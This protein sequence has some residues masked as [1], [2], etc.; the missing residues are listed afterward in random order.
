MRSVGSIFDPDLAMARWQHTDL[1]DSSPGRVEGN[2]LSSFI[3][4]KILA[5]YPLRREW[6]YRPGIPE[7]YNGDLKMPP[8]SPAKT[9]C[10]GHQR[11]NI[12]YNIPGAQSREDHASKATM[13]PFHLS[14][15]V[16]APNELTDA[17]EFLSRNPDGNIRA[18]WAEQLRRL[19]VLGADLF[20]TQAAWYLATPPEI[21]RASEGFMPVLTS[22]ILAQLG[23]GC[24]SGSGSLCADLA[25]SGA[26]PRTDYFRLAR[27]TG[28]PWGMN[29]PGQRH[30]DVPPHELERPGLT[31]PL[32][33]GATLSGMFSRSG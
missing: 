16:P 6:A 21:R 18:E 7:F 8:L 5:I 33:Y 25:E 11:S 3:Q 20:P 26:F 2:V 24:Q 14:D 10:A 28:L 22:H 29:W 30:L 32:N 13:G 15:S 12:H 23:K 31:K 4:V 9:I 27:N 17:L 19:D 1:T